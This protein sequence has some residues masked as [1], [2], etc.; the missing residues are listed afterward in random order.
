MHL[1]AE[2]DLS[3]GPTRIPQPEWEE[4][5]PGQAAGARWLDAMVK[6]S[7]LSPLDLR[8]L[9]RPESRYEEQPARVI[10][11]TYDVH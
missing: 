7:R 2:L 11:R 1:A 10:E 3:T 8:Q 9:T 4:Q 5:T 6:M